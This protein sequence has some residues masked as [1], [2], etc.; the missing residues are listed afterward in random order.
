MNAKLITFIAALTGATAGAIGGYFFA[1]NRLE[2]I[3]EARLEEE[4][5]ETRKFYNMLH[6]RGD[7][8]TPEVAVE[9]LARVA[10]GLKDDPRPTIGSLLTNQRYRVASSA[11]DAVI[12]RGPDRPYIIRHDEFMDNDS[13]HDQ[14]SLTWYIG[15]GVL[16]D[17][18]DEVVEDIDFHVG[19][20]NLNCFGELSTDDNTVY[21]RNEKTL[22]EYEIV[23]HEGSYA[24]VVHGITKE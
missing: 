11:R 15:D 5:E 12:E 22:V 21:V 2:S 13:G 14:K 3:Y 10:A 9:T 23:Q 8:E 7:F 4:I 24:E 16:A 17:E 1:K 19:E 20:A 6:K 18:D